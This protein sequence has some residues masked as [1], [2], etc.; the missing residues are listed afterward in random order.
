MVKRFKVR[1]IAVI[2]LLFG[3]IAFRTFEVNALAE[4]E[5]RNYVEIVARGK[6]Y[7]YYDEPVE[8]TNHLVEEQIFRRK[9]NASVQKKMEEVRLHTHK[10]IGV[11]K[12]L[13]YSYPKLKEFVDNVKKSSFVAPTD[14]RVEFNPNKSPVFTLYRDKAG[15]S[16]DEQ[17]L[18]QAI[19]RLWHTGL[20]GKIEVKSKEGIGTEV[21]IKL[22]IKALD[23]G[24]KINATHYEEDDDELLTRINIEFSDIYT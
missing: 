20:G 12:A 21:V 16:V 19:Y 11:D 18:Y 17:A 4:Q 24:N 2:F 1:L 7:T 15:E 9:I 10:G 14:A 22:P 23:D 3:V 6:S 13:I 8:S 5:K